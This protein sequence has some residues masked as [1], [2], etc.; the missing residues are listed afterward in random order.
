MMEFTIYGRLPSLNEYIKECRS[1]KYS[2]NKMKQEVEKC[3]YF[4]IRQAKLQKVTKYPVTLE[5]TWYEQNSRRDVDN[6]VF[7]TKFIQ[8]ALV[9]A[10][11]I[12]NDGQKQISSLV[13]HVIIDKNNPRV[14]VKI[15]MKDGK[16]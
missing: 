15:C 5:I 13:H 6:I 1:N 14:E 12:V 7:A 9:N 10:G 8:D 3:V 16:A 4:A 11:I 2:A